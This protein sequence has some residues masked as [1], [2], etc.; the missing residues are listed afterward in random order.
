MRA[1]RD[2][3]KS[4]YSFPLHHDTL[5]TRVASHLPFIVV[6]EDDPGTQKALARLLRVAGFDPVIYSSA[7]EF[8]GATLP[9]PP[10]CLVLD[11]HLGVL[12]GLELLR[13]LR[14]DGSQLPVI[15]MTA[16]DDR[17]VVQE[18]H[19]NGC[20]AF[21]QKEA[22]GETLLALLRSLPAES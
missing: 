13:Q 19:R 14:A 18:A 20:L 22:D 2:S 17:R 6:V 15:M 8:L 11:V 9:R 21:L 1:R 5:L 16:H 12:S 4:Q 3:P 10:A 7:E